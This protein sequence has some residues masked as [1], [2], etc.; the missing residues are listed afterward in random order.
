MKA[1]INEGDDILV[2]NVGSGLTAIHM[3]SLTNGSDSMIYAFGAQNEIRLK[4]INQK[5]QNFG[6]K[7][8]LLMLQSMNI[9]AIFF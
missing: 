1:L 2:V 3:A 6:A 9:K 7:C 5:I 8:I 4:Q